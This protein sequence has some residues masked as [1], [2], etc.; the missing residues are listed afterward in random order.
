MRAWRTAAR[1][2]LQGTYEDGRHGKSTG[3]H[4]IREGLFICLRHSALGILTDLAA[5]FG[6]V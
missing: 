5:L 4:E 3:A 6:E 2:R 1:Y